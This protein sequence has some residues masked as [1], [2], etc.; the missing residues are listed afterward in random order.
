MEHATDTAPAAPERAEPS[1]RLWRSRAE[2]RADAARARIDEQRARQQAE[3]ERLETES[4]HA[5]LRAQLD[6]QTT[7]AAAKRRDQ[8]RTLRQRIS[9]AVVLAAANIGVNAAAVLGQI[10]A[11]MYG[12][13]WKWWQAVP[14]AV[15]VE[16]VAVNV[17]YLAHDKMIKGFSAYGLRLLSYA[18][19]VGV[20]LFNYSHNSGL[21]ETK[22]FAGVFGAA[23]VLSPVL[24]QIYSQW[25]HWE[26][27]REQGLLEQR[28]LRFPLLRWVIPSLRAETWAAFKYG[29]AED[30]RSPQVALAEIRA[31]SAM[32]AAWRGLGD[33]RDGLIRAQ[34][35]VLTVTQLVIADLE[36]A[37]DAVNTSA[38]IGAPAIVAREVTQAVTGPVTVEVAPANDAVNTSATIECSPEVPASD[39]APVTAAVTSDA[40]DDDPDSDR[41]RP[42]EQDNRD[43]EKWIRACI[44]KGRT[45]TYGD[46]VERYKFSR[47]WARLRVQAAR[48]EMTAKGYRF[49]PANVVQS[50]AEPVTANGSRSVH[51]ED[52]DMTAVG[53]AGG[54]S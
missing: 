17:G 20:G 52:I 10:L 12:L 30:I 26:S 25:R 14:L 13:D 34:G 46:V 21:T 11:L 15:V 6:E 51:A 33:A 9:L 50:P 27:M 42:D 44:R 40:G 47:G 16:S 35:D 43:A 41:D 39:P 53:S 7:T 28:P 36:A 23:S 49:L 45:P 19:G 8:R 24:W 31:M 38:T 48:A 29:V 4:E 2:R 37:R 22:E 32:D 1:R 3:R 18:I 5:R 54:A